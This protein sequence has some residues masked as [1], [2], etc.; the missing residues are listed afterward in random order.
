[1][2]GRSK[3][4]LSKNNG[5]TKC[6][7][8]QKKYK[9]KFL[10]ESYPINLISFNKS[11]H[12]DMLLHPTQKPIALME[13]LIKT[14]T[15]EGMIIFDATMGSGTTGV[16]CINTSRRFIGIELDEKYFNLAKTR[17]EK[18]QEKRFNIVKA[19]KTIF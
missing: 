14:Y 19:Q 4:R 2:R 8:T 10:K 9:G 11:S 17:I 15:N 16:A 6:Y 18:A 3:G 13:Y 5:R 1:M 12:K 7:G